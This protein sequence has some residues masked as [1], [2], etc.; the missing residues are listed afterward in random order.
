MYFQ[1]PSTVRMVYPAIVYG[2]ENIDNAY[3]NNGVY[4]SKK[5]YSI[6]LINKD[7]DSELI[8]KINN[9]PTARY[10][11]QFVKDNL[12]HTIFSLSY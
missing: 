12:Y 4:L 2:V 5:S 6:T 10:S 9:L 7:P 3:A 1:P 8:D 11:T